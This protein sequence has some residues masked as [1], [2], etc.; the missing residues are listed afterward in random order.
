MIAERPGLTWPLE[1]ARVE[2]DG[3]FSLRQPFAPGTLLVLDF[4]EFVY[5]AVAQLIPGKYHD[6]FNHHHLTDLHPTNRAVQAGDFR[7]Q[8]GLAGTRWE[9][10]RP[11]NCAA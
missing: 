3:F 9:S 6:Y 10:G 8:D 2:E 7:L 11:V 5:A 1:T 4:L